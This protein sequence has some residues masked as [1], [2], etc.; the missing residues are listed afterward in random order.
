MN[1]LKRPP[2]TLENLKFVLSVIASIRNMSLDVELKYVDIQE[3]YRT[4]RMY[5]VNVREKEDN[6]NK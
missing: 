1:D 2:D 6:R 4:L 3:R 5:K